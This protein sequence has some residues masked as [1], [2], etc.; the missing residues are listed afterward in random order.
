MSLIRESR[1]IAELSP[2]KEDQKLKKNET[3]IEVLPNLTCSVKILHYVY[4]Y[5]RLHRKSQA[6]MCIVSTL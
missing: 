2:L 6:L 1:V 4:I 3:T 5:Y